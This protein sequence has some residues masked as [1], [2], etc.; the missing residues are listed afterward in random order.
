MKRSADYRQNLRAVVGFEDSARAGYVDPKHCHD[1]AQLAFAL[2]GVMSI[3][4]E[5]ASFILPPNRALWIPAGAVHETTCRGPVCFQILYFEPTLDA[6]PQVSHVLE[7][8]ALLRALIH[9]VT[10]F[11]P[12]IE[13]SPRELKIV[14]LLLDEITR[15]PRLPVWADMPCDDRLRRVCS[16]IIANPADDRDIDDWASLAGMSRR[17]FTRLFK[18]QTGMGLGSW[19]Q[20]VRVMEAVS[21]LSAG[22]SITNVAYDVGYDSPSAFTAMFHRAFGAPPSAY[23]LS[24]PS[25]WNGQG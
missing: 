2:S 8:S 3:T 18:T 7:V 10:N 11:D 15:M 21:R 22:Q 13:D 23:A 12:A 5:N 14:S 24:N 20:Q 4:T 25:A 9:E 19:R 17:S 6:L 16:A 1:K